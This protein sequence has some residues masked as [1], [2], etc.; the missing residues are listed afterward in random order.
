MG[1]IYLPLELFNPCFALWHTPSVIL[2]NKKVYDLFTTSKSQ[3][4]VVPTTTHL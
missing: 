1:V 2:T 4:L 3:P